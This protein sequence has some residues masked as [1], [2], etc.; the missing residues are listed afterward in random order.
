VKIDK[1]IFSSSVE[2]SPFWNIQSKLYRE[3]LNIEPVCLLYGKKSDTNMSEQ[4]G[5]VIE[6]EINQDLPYILQLTWSK[7]H[8]PIN[9]PETVWLIGDIDMIPLQHR[10]FTT[11][12]VSAPDDALL[13]LNSTSG[14]LQQGCQLRGG[15]DLPAHYFVGKG[16]RF[17]IFAQGQA[18]TKQIE[19]IVNSDRYGLGP[20]HAKNMP[21]HENYGYYWCAEEMYSSELL[22]NAIKSGLINFIP[23]SYSNTNDTQR[24][25]RSSWCESKQDYVYTPARVTAGEFVDIH[26]QRPYAKQEAALNRILKLLP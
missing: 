6:C 22:E 16:I 10:Y 21:K 4:W 14:F 1:V 19:Y 7:F 12:I 15:A 5:H 9:E 20:V 2:Y 8:Y 25:D 24:I 13:H 23:F 26:C 17:S 18:F 3:M 11:N